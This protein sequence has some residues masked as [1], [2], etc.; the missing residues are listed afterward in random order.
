MRVV[1]KE[2]RWCCSTVCVCL[3]SF[4]AL[5]E[6]TSFMFPDAF[7]RYKSVIPEV[8]QCNLISAFHRRL[9]GNDEAEKLKCATAW[10]CVRARH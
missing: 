7:D 3:C 9:T 8:E 10:R 6:G 4:S 1:D 5:Q 2:S